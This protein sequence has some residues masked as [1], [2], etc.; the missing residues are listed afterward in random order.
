[1]RTPLAFTLFS[2][3]TAALLS[4]CA[5]PPSAA[6]PAIVTAKSQPA[7]TSPVKLKVLAINDFHGYLKAPSGG[8][9]IEDKNNPGKSI[10]VE[11]GGAEHIATAVAELRAKNPNHI[12]VAAGDLIGATPLLSALFRDEPTVES[13]S[14][15]GLEVSAVGNHEFD[16][17]AAELLR[18]Q[19][20]G[21]HPTEGCKGPTTFKGARYQYL[22]AS[23]EV[24]ADGDKSGKTL[25]PP[26][27]VK[28]FEGIPVAF[29]GLTLKATPSMVV[30]SGVAGLRFNDEAKTV[31]ALVPELRAKGIEAIV[32]LIHEGGIPTGDYNECPGI[33]GPIVEVVN[34][35]DKA[36]DAVITG[37]THRAYNCRIDGRLVTSGDKYGTIVTEIDIELDRKSR[38]VIS[39][40][41]NNVIVRTAGFAKDP[42]QTALI[43][44]YD[45]LA[46]P[47]TQ[48]VIGRIGAALPRGTNDAGESVIGQVIAD[49]QLEA[50]RDAGAQIAF[51]NPGGVRSALP[52]PV[53]GQ[54][55]FEDLY[56]VQP[57]GNT[58][59][60]MTLV[61]VQIM[62]LLEQQWRGQTGGRVMHVSEGFTYTWDGAAPA[63]QRIVQGSIRLNGKQIEPATE[64]RV[65]VNAFMADGG[66]NFSIFKQGRD[67]RVGILD[68]DALE[69]YLKS[70]PSFKPGPLNRITRVN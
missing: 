46:Q 12:F 44:S 64:Y 26:Y 51:L 23:T 39:A 18:M 17:G 60:T 11:A 59:V 3:F 69:L 43:N 27:F 65:T 54:V 47:L 36:V 50:A 49:S 10:N 70:R 34:K 22:A 41:A 57:F 1:M 61:G 68:V 13:L 28:T 48:R 4:A 63:G 38:D 66:D 21:C 31:N 55:K 9:R 5:A 16:K 32:V 2:V 25:L 7:N 37:H 58:V 35:L 6:P 56:S 45:K 33:S 29:I 42:Q 62:Q 15:M 53:D 40:N 30:P 14:L 67:R 52:M 8:I 20:G 19:R 24:V